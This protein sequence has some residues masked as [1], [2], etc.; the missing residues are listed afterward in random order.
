MNVTFLNSSYLPSKGGVEN[1]LF[2]L[3]RESIAAGNE[4]LIIAG[5]GKRGGLCR[6]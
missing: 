2:F 5:G 3:S 1:S 6:R 4:T